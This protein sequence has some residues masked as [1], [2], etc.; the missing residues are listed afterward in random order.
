LACRDYRDCAI[1]KTQAWS[2]LSGRLPPDVPPRP[3]VHFVRNML[4]PP[5]LSPEGVLRKLATQIV[6]GGARELHWANVAG[7]IQGCRNEYYMA[8]ADALAHLAEAD[9]A[10]RLVDVYKSLPQG[11]LYEICGAMTT[12]PVGKYLELSWNLSTW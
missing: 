12:T 5:P 8:H 7:A 6:V 11:D 9:P 3:K 1:G 10:N 4:F 2:N